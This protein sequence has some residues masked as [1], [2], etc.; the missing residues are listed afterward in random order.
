MTLWKTKCGILFK[1]HTEYLKNAKFQCNIE[2]NI[3]KNTS[4][5]Q[6]FILKNMLKI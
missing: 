5:I 4:M 3:N 1:R 6:N 2:V